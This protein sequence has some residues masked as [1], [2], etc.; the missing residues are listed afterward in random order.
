M[1]WNVERTNGHPSQRA[2]LLAR[3]EP[4]PY[5]I[6]NADGG[7]PLVF[8]CDHASHAIPKCLGNLGLGP[9]DLR[10]HI[11]WDIGAAEVTLRLATRFDSP[12]VLSGYSRLVIDCNR[13]PESESSIVETSDGT[14]VPGNIGI[15]SADASRRREE[16]FRP[17]HEAIS[18]VLEGFR[19][20]GATPVYVAVHSFTAKIEGGPPRPWHYG[21]LWDEDPR[22]A[23]PLIEALRNNGG[24]Y[25]GDN[26][27]YSGRD[28]FDFSQE[29]HASSKGLPSALVEIREDL[30]R[31]ESGV[32]KYADMLGDALECA[33]ANLQPTAEGR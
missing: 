18:G 14:A 2:K 1:N 3:D 27:P 9:R 6:E 29:F 11:G 33:L 30:I 28:H 13:A 25:V 8:T 31:H 16:L 22:I 10:R 24:I 12:A 32:A 5:R 26:Q 23:V 21:V 20:T 19:R 15:G 4:L 17:Y 7:A